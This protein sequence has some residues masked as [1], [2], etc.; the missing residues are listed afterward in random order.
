ML[1]VIS[2]LHNDHDIELKND[3]NILRIVDNHKHLGDAL[4]SNTNWSKHIVSIINSASKQ[5][6]YIRELKFQF[7]KRTLNKLY[8][9]YIRPFLEYAYGCNLPDTNRLE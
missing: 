5:I 2:N 8:C 1:M 9:T 7:P 3:E 4:S 6:S